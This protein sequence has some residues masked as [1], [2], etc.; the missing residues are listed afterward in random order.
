M[1]LEENIARLNEEYGSMGIR[2]ELIEGGVVDVVEERKFVLNSRP[3]LKQTLKKRLG[4]AFNDTLKW[5][6]GRQA[7]KKLE[8]VR[9]KFRPALEPPA[10]KK[11]LIN[12][13]K[14][15]GEQELQVSILQLLTNNKYF[16]EAPA[17]RSMHHNYEGG[18]L[19]HT[20]QTVKVAL[21][22]VDNL[23]HDMKVDVDLVIA[24]AVLHDIGKI[25]CYAFV[26]GG[27]EITSL[28][29]KQDHIVNGIKLVSQHVKSSKLDALIHVVASHH[30]LTDWG[31]PVPPQIPEA[32]IVHFAENLSSKIMG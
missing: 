5:H 23:D 4:M 11:A 14:R 17:A 22:I 7:V 21:G 24:G 28:G 30:N 27:V 19:E 25:N 12:Y 16:Y 18:L 1:Y 31:S 26:P 29:K 20:L 3:A 10:M 2:F 6:L 8:D 32:W 13:I 15:I 9:L